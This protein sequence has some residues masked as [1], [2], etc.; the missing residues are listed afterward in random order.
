MDPLSPIEKEIRVLTPHLKALHKLGIKT[1]EDMMY[2]FPVRYGDTAEIKN[3]QSLIPGEDAVV[4]G[5]ISGLKTSKAFVKK[6]PM[7]D[8]YLEDETGRVKIVWFNQPYI[9]KMLTDGAM[10][11]V[12]GKVT[13]RKKDESLYFSNP[14]IEIAN[15]IPTGVGSSLFG[16][17]G[18]AHNLYPVYPESKGVTSNWMYHA[19][20]RIFKSGTLDLLPDPLPQH[21]LDTYHLPD[22]KTAMIWI[23]AP[24]KESDAIAARKRFAFQEIFTI[25]LRKEREKLTWQRNQAF[26]IN[27][28]KKKVDA[29]IKT[30]PFEATDAQKKA[31]DTILSDFT[32]GFPMSRLL[33]GDVGSGKTAVAAASVFSVVTSRPLKHPERMF[34]Q[35]SA[36]ADD[37]ATQD[38]GNLQVAYMAPTEI[39]AKQQFENFVTF[40][41]GTGIQVGLIT[42]SG[43]KKFP[44][45]TDPSA[46]T[47]ISKTQLLKWIKNGEIPIVVGTHALVYK[48]VEFKHLAFAVIDEQHRFG[49]LQRQKLTTKNDLAPHLL[50]MTATP[51]PRTL[52]LTIYGD[53]DLS[54]LDQMPVGRKPIITKVVLPR[55]RT[56]TY[57]DIKKEL[58][59]GRQLYVIC[60]RIEE[61]DPTKENAVIAKSVTEEAKRLK[62][63][64]FTDWSIGVLHSKMTPA[65]KEKVMSDFAEHKTDILVATSVVEVGV[66]V[67]NATQIIIEGAERFGLSQLHQL[68]GRVI[69]SNH[70]AYCYVFTESTGDKTKERMKA[71][72]TAKNGFELAEFD[73]RARGAGQLYGQKQW[74]VGDLAMEALQNI[75]LVEASRTEARALITNDPDLKKY[76][77]LRQVVES[78]TDKIHF[79]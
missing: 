54:V 6:T 59:A 34:G 14:K 73:L 43:C 19:V 78:N 30:F 35:P 42:G 3:I 69:R 2:H 17:E 57:E 33:E 52:S 75:K 21:I 65:D 12:Q 5:R 44:S 9:A 8:A 39:L 32:R 22:L 4:F 28:D 77:L 13:L 64:V 51:I 26:V 61:V 25:H 50:S 41:E 45:K 23:H 18:D 56:S 60:P 55:D 15:K 11:R 38:F 63:E 62:A 7:S 67:P 16:A 10:V 20:E 58:H 79:E 71:L 74:G 48:S 29:F 66:N 1:V 49:T 70:Q 31:I 46:S 53:L 72:L 37:L 76:P 40:F 36:T 27:T 68:R 24:K 47:S